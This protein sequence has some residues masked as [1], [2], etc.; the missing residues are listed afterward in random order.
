MAGRF[1]GEG[2]GKVPA[3]Q[4]PVQ[5]MIPEG[6]EAPPGRRARGK[7]RR[8]GLTR[9][10][11][12]AWFLLILPAGLAGY[13]GYRHI[14]T[15]LPEISSLSDYRPPVITTVYADD[16]Q[17]IAEFYEQRR[18]VL[19]ISQIPPRLIHAFVAAEDARFFEHAGV[20]ILSILRALSKNLSAGEVV[21]GGSTITQ[22]V[23]KSFLLTPEKSY[24]RKL[25]EALLA[26]RIEKAFTKK[27]ILYLYLNQ[28]YLGNGAYGVQAA[29]ENYFGKPAWELSLAECATL[30]GLPPAPSAYSPAN[31]PEMGRKRRRYVLERMVAEGYISHSEAASAMAERLTLAPRKNWFIETAPYFSEHIRRYVGERYGQDALYRDGLQIHTTVN[32]AMQK[33][34]MR[35]VRD[36]LRDLDKRQGWRGPIQR[37]GPEEREA[38]IHELKRRQTVD[39]IMP[40][41]TGVAET[42]AAETGPAETSVAAGA[43][44]SPAVG[45]IVRGVIVPATPASLKDGSG[46]RPTSGKRIGGGAD[47]PGDGMANAGGGVA[48]GVADGDLIIHMG[49]ALGIIRREDRRWARNATLAEGDVIWARIM[50]FDANR[51][52]WRLALEQEPEVEGALM[53]IETGSGNVK[54]L[55][56]GRDFAKSQFNRAVQSLRQPGSSFKPIIYAAA[57]DRGFTPLTLL[58]DTPFAYDDGFTIWRPTNY[59]DKFTGPIRLRDAL[60]KS[61]NIPVI[62]V[63]DE[64]GVDYAV[65]YARRLGFTSRLDRRL[66]LALGASGVSLMEMVTAY[67]VFANQGTLRHP[68]FIREIRNREGHLLPEMAPE[69]EQVMEAS[70]AYLMTS[71]LESVV[72]KG[73]GR[74]VRELNRPV[75]GKTG[76][77]NDFRDAWFMGYTPEYVTG[78]WV[79]FDQERPLGPKETGSRAAS[80]IWLAFM[81]QALADRPVTDFPVPEGVTFL[82]IDAQTGRRAESRTPYTFTECFKADNL[83]GV[84]RKP[85]AAAAAAPD[86]QASNSAGAPP[87][88]PQSFQRPAGKPAPPQT[89]TVITGPEDF[90]KSGI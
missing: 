50:E 88:R 9:W 17:R 85:L 24:R 40:V 16:G 12:W 15:D 64:I 55:V 89:P 57:L 60:A 63:L 53:C 83:P 75:A 84:I 21:Q 68:V 42:G 45:A 5:E 72:Q 19:P 18:I 20:D 76:T 77:T 31:H 23:T 73:T 26:Y 49:G 10:F 1:P 80:P 6:A 47:G 33:A 65:T 51:G 79:G 58:S 36:G 29:A 62:R 74:R 66:S 35:D 78:V 39:F 82:E 38:F 71:L 13:A 34:A 27:E 11:F 3:F 87:D 70:T 81:R 41:E 7:R 22:Q 59:D 2:D 25:K 4:N 56:G 52:L 37:L 44:E 90:F 61:R 43:G 30:A 46:G 69:P 32:V 48:V 54:A 14:R 28:I 8:G 67:S 86:A